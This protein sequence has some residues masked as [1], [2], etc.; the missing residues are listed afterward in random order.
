MSHRQP[1]RNVPQPRDGL[2]S[3]ISRALSPRSLSACVRRCPSQMHAGGAAAS[4]ESFPPSSDFLSLRVTPGWQSVVLDGFFISS[5]ICLLACLETCLIVCMQTRLSAFLTACACKCI[6]FSDF[7]AFFPLISET[8]EQCY[9]GPPTQCVT[10]VNDSIPLPPLDSTSH[11]CHSEEAQCGFKGRASM[12]CFTLFTINPSMLPS[13]FTVQWRKS[14]G[15]GN[16]KQS[17]QYNA[18]QTPAY[19]P[20]HQLKQMT[21]IPCCCCVFFL[22]EKPVF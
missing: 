8:L 6:R 3:L 21:N 7:S 17:E 1:F 14:S 2:W 18:E 13:V 9:F 10:T 20:W 11:V 12:S 16:I 4:C 19:Q 5:C 15:K 22:L